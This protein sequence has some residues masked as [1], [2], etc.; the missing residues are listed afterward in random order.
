MANLVSGQNSHVR[1]VFSRVNYRTPWQGS[2]W[3][4]PISSADWGEHQGA[5]A[6]PIVKLKLDETGCNDELGGW[7]EGI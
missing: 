5:F 1:E 4:I 7:Y 2:I 6:N 3:V